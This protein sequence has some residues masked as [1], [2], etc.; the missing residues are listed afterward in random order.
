MS[1]L[2]VKLDQ[3]LH[4]L[5]AEE[6]STHGYAT[7]LAQ[8][9]IDDGHRAAV[10]PKELNTDVVEWFRQIKES[11]ELGFLPEYGKVPNGSRKP[12][13][14]CRTPGRMIYPAFGGKIEMI[15]EMHDQLDEKIIN[16]A[17]SDKEQKVDEKPQPPIESKKP[18]RKFRV[19]R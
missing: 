3:K 18:V 17:K 19:I 10:V 16:I 7:Q 15:D 5:E 2:A 11:R 13:D 9:W 1:W 14:G 4:V 8:R 6:R 12:G